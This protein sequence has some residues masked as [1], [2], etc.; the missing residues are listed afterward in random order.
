MMNAWSLFKSLRVKKIQKKTQL[1]ILKFCK[2][3]MESMY[4]LG[5]FPEVTEFV[6]Y[7]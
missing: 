4:Q 5:Y 7:S 1:R 2:H 6:L 3:W